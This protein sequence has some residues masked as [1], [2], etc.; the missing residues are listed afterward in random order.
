MDWRNKPAFRNGSTLCQ[1][2][3]TYIGPSRWNR[4]DQYEFEGDRF[5]RLQSEP[6]EGGTALSVLA[7]LNGSHQ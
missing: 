7:R 4:P 1:L 3:S 6:V 5:E 2:N